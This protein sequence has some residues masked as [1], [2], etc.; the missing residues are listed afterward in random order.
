MEGGGVLGVA[1]VGYTYVLEEMGIR[2]LRVGGTSAGS[3]DAVLVA[4]LGTPQERKSEK[5][6]KELA[7]VDFWRFVDGGGAARVLLQ[8]LYTLNR[9]LPSSLRQRWVAARRDHPTYIQKVRHNS[10]VHAS[11]WKGGSAMFARV[12][13][14]A[15]R[16]ERLEEGYHAIEEHVIPALR[17]QTG[18]SG[19]LLLANPE[20]GKVLAVSLWENEQDMHATDEAS[21]WFRVFG[22]AAVE[23]TVTDVERY[24]VYRA[25]LTHPQS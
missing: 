21:Y 6:V 14:F 11:S 23:G 5:I 9:H 16:S 20:S 2:F 24:E 10:G 18:Y 19:G 3:I 17:M 12:S 25:Q 8:T 22:A 13:Q 1:L 4:G 15:V 7:K